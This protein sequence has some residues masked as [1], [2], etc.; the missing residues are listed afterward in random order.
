MKKKSISSEQNVE[1]ES[2]KCCSNHKCKF[3]YAFF[4]IVL[5]IL[6]AVGEH[7]F[8]KHNLSKI[9]EDN[10][11]ETLHAIEE[12]KKGYDLSVLSLKNDVSSLKTEVSKIVIK[13]ENVICT[14]CKKME[15]RKKW[16][17]WLALKEKM[18]ASEEFG[19]ELEAFNVLFHY[20]N[21]LIAIVNDLTK[22]V[23]VISNIETE[24]DN[25]IDT[26][27]RYLRKVVR[28][29]KIDYRKLLEVSGYVLSSIKEE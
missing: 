12:S 19:K 26:C 14:Y 22:G 11:A 4:T 3:C 16:K 15:F 9:S 24:K 18:E 8:N 10:K 27:K 21:E 1:S 29:K 2:K 28:I 13:D 20:D 5:V 7:F 6:C 17:T 25:I 23:D